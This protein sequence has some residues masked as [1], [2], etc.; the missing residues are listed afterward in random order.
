M[1]REATHTVNGEGADPV[2]LRR[3]EHTPVFCL[4]H[5]SLPPLSATEQVSLKKKKIKK[6]SSTVPFVSG[7]KPDTEDSGKQK[8]L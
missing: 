8:K 3:C 4:Q 2:W 6:V 1:G 5:P 7:R